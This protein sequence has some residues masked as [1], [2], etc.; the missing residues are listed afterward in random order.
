MMSDFNNVSMKSYLEIKVPL[1]YN[2]RWFVELRNV[3]KEIPVKWQ[4]GYFHITMAFIDETPK[5]L[6]LRP[7][8]EKYLTRF[9]A[10]RLTLDKLDVFEASNEY[11]VNLTSTNIPHDFHELTEAIRLDMKAVGCQ[12]KYEFRLHV[13]LGK[14]NNDDIML[15][16]LQNLVSSISL[17]PFTLKLTD[18]D[19]RVF[20]GK[21]I[22]ETKLK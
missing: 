13:T 20:R 17:T 3:L 2:A 21:V 7:I 4:K 12:I 6:D 5:K 22:Y 11:I 18:V 9:Q 1:K 16:K 10:P 15:S 14:I 19:C 8:L